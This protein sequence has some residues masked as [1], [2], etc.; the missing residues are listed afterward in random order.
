MARH[1][2]GLREE[3]TAMIFPSRYCKKA[4]PDDLLDP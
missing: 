1:D 4:N 3:S 2:I